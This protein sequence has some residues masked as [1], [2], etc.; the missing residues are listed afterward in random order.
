MADVYG[1]IGTN[2]QVVD[3]PSPGD[4]WANMLGVVRP[5]TN[6]IAQA[7]GTWVF[8]CSDCCD[9]Y[10]GKVEEIKDTKFKANAFEWPAASG[11]YWQTEAK[12]QGYVANRSI[13]AGNV[14][15]AVAG[16][17]WPADFQKYSD[18]DNVDYTFTAATDFVPFAVAYDNYC[19]GIATQARTYKNA[20]MAINNGA[21]TDVEKIAAMDD[22]YTNTILLW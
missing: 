22:Y 19:V 7:D 21:G 14:I 20:L 5:T 10:C 8:G 11:K 15:A 18:K 17:D 4:G 12:Y 2:K 13:R 9:Y 3:G 6:H 16:V 1:F